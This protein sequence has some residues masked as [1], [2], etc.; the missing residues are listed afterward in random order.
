MKTRVAL[1]YEYKVGDQVLLDTPGILRKL[2]TPRSRPYPVTKV[3]K[4]STIQVQKVIMSERMNI[5]RISPFKYDP[6]V[7]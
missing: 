1:P 4:N 6:G 7:K 5:R 2:S 3:Y